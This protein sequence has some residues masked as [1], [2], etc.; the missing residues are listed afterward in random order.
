MP[1]VLA[2]MRLRMPYVL[3]CIALVALV[4]AVLCHRGGYMGGT[5]MGGPYMGGG[6]YLL[7]AAGC[8]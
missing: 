1:Y 3:I 2:R 6:P 8:C 7:P 4:H 5:Y